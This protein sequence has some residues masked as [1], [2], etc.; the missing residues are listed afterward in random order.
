VE[1][2]DRLTRGLTIAYHV[3]SFEELWHLNHAQ[4]TSKTDLTGLR[5]FNLENPSLSG[6]ESLLDTRKWLP[7]PNTN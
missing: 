4:T 5:I 1:L 6:P 7:S 2:A 3:G